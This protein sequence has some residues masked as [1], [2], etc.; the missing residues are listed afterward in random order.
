MNFIT[1]VDF[2]KRRKVIRKYLKKANERIARTQV[3][4]IKIKEVRKCKSTQ[5]KNS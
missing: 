3:K 5:Q 4:V 2:N 1:A